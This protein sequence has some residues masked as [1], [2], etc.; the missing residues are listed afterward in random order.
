MS[1]TVSA[2][3]SA[4]LDGRRLEDRDAPASGGKRRQEIREEC[5]GP[6]GQERREKCRRR[7]EGQ[8]LTALA[9]IPAER[10]QRGQRQDGHR[11]EPAR[12]AWGVNPQRQHRYDEIERQHD[13]PQ[14]PQG[15][16]APSRPGR[17][18]RAAP[19]RGAVLHERRQRKD[20]DDQGVGVEQEVKRALKVSRRVRAAR[21]AASCRSRRRRERSAARSR[22]RTPRP[23]TDATAPT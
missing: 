19:E 20:P 12:A 23:K 18:R 8:R 14:T 16:A 4:T 2:H 21:R 15:T 11:E 10:S 3:V 5:T 6:R 17:R 9:S 1:V 22:A 7:C 13:P